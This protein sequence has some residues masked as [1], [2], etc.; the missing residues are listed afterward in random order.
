MQCGGEI[1]NGCPSSKSNLRRLSPSGEN[2]EGREVDAVGSAV[3]D[4]EDGFPAELK[5]DPDGGEKFE[6]SYNKS[7]D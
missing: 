7:H 2:T 6:L 5:A 3:S 4:A 1:I